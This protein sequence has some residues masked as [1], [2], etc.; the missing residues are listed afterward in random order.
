MS[1]KTQPLQK[2]WGAR[3]G[4]ATRRMNA[5]HSFILEVQAAIVLAD[6]V[7]T[8]PLLLLR[9]P[10]PFLMNGNSY[11]CAG[12]RVVTWGWQVHARDTLCKWW[13]GPSHVLSFCPSIILYLKWEGEPETKARIP[14]PASVILWS[15]FLGKLSIGWNEI[16]QTK[17]QVWG[18]GCSSRLEVSKI[19]P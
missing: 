9:Q 1:F 16:Q 14:S 17:S 15:V 11:K 4:I 2:Q 6:M 19:Y 8:G 7:T 13:V 10:G 18:Q 3:L 12:Y 5:L